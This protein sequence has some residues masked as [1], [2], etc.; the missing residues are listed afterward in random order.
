LDNNSIQQIEGAT[1]WPHL[2]RLSLAHNLIASVDNSGLDKLDKL[3]H[4]CLVNNLIASMAAF[5]RM[6]ALAELYL[7]N[8]L[9]D[10]ARSIFH[11]KV[12][13]MCLLSTKNS[14]AYFA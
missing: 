3:H 7:S 8:N 14:R 2:Q 1:H 10:N 6:S 11:L 13:V 5:Q 12:N 9:V 4:L